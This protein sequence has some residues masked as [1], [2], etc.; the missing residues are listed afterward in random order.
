MTQGQENTGHPQGEPP[1]SGPERPADAG[2]GPGAG[3]E[4]SA[5]PGAPQPEAGGPAQPQSP[6]QP[7]PGQAQGQAP[8]RPAGTMKLAAVQPP[9][10]PQQGPDQQVSGQQPPAGTMQFS[11]AKP[12][13]R[14]APGTPPVPPQGAPGAQPQQGQPGAPQGQP[15]G[16]PPQGQPGMQSPQA[17]PGPYGAPQGAPAPQ[18]GPYPPPG[19]GVPGA[20]GQ[21]GGAP[22]VYPPPGGP[23]GPGGPMAPGPGGAAHPQP[24][25]P[26]GFGQ[27]PQGGPGFV[28]GPGGAPGGPSR[29]IP[30]P[31]IIAIVVVVVL[32][33]G[34]GGYFLLAGGSGGDEAQQQPPAL[35]MSRMWNTDLKK[36]DSRPREELGMRS[37]WLVDGAVVYGDK[38]GVRAYDDQTGKQEWELETPKGAG[39][40]CALPTEPNGD[41]VAAAVFDSG[42][43]DCSFLSVFD[44]GTG[45]TL[46]VRNLKGR[47]SEDRPVVGISHREVVV[48]I[49]DTYSGYAISGGAGKWSLK[50]PAGECTASF[51]ISN[52]YLARVS[53]CTKAK[54]KRELLIQ[55]HELDSMNASVPGEKMEVQRVLSDR[56][57]VLLMADSGENRALRT[58]DS[59]GK[60]KPDRSIELTGDLDELDLDARTT[61]VDEDSKILLTTYANHTGL[62]ALDLKTGKR[63]WKRAGAV[64][65]ALDDENVIAV[66]NS[67][68]SPAHHSSQD[69]ELL[70]MGLR[71]AKTKLMGT[72]F[73]QGHDLPSP[74]SMSMRW[75][76]Y[77]VLYVEGES[78]TTG[79]PFLRAYKASKGSPI[80]I[81][82][83]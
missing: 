45:H 39:A 10:A 24:G 74:T 36:S 82:A 42:G 72:L 77:G 23:M 4:R 29:G 64:A 30:V 20:Y 54:P 31:A 67:H 48:A 51:G 73:T 16:Q 13:G 15:G 52:E 44:T 40:V 75:D 35:S 17:Q 32:I 25:A 9:T 65:V 61:M 46:W 6:E 8:A 68:G 38:D 49:G 18:P 34:T 37:V 22:G 33:I 79:R 43:G 26:Q 59:E 80:P 76:G 12:G 62:A 41:G 21:Q 83:D 11:M 70:S 69:P 14:P 19:Q 60:P 7:R 55:E 57:L 28:P 56:P 53:D 81:P 58:F 27:P 71:D 47:Q 63:L 1:G 5:A 50:W 3:Q 66:G 2:Q 78:L